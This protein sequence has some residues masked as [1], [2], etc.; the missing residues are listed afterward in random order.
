MAQLRFSEKRLTVWAESKTDEL[1]VCKYYSNFYSLVQR[2]TSRL[3]DPSKAL[4]VFS[5][6]CPLSPLSKLY[7]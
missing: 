4:A 1:K 5:T 3:L 7:F 6:H 2:H